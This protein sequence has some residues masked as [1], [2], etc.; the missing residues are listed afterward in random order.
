MA[1][2]AKTEKLEVLKPELGAKP[3]VYYKNLHLVESCFLAGSVLRQIGG[4]KD[5]AADVAVTLRQETGLIAT[6]Q[7]DAFGDF[8]FD[9][10]PRNSDLYFLDF[11]SDGKLT[12][13]LEVTLENA[14]VSLGEI[15]L[16]EAT[17]V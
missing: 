3:R 17:P 5:C 16:D 8:K 11:Q 15:E 14:S 10:L 13:T 1:A 6:L 9:A 7:T 12:K 4:I 2:M